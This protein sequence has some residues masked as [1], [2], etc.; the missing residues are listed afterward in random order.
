M[1]REVGCGQPRRAAGTMGLKVPRTRGGVSSRDG[2]QTGLL[3]AEGTASWREG[4]RLEVE[5]IPAR[6]CI[7]HIFSHAATLGVVQRTP[8]TCT[9]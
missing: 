3:G 6:R 8:Y 9:P 5:D 7:I 2:P 4:T 1:G